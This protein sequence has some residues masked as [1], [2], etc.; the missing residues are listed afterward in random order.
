[1]DAAIDFAAKEASRFE[2]AKMFGDGGEGNVEGLGE[3]GDGGFALR[4]T[5]EDGAT[6]GVGEGTEGAVQ[7]GGGIVNHMV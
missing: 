5:C 6:G 3:F 2:D 7:S 4:E 1:V